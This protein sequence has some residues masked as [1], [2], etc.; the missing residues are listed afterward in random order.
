MTLAPARHM[1]HREQRCT[2][3]GFIATAAGVRGDGHN[4]FQCQ[5]CGTSVWPPREPL[6]SPPRRLWRL[7]HGASL[8]EAVL[9][10]TR[11][12][13]VECRLFLNERFCYSE[14]HASAE[15]AVEAAN[16]HRERRETDGWC[17]ET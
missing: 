17:V 16:G 8:L 7:R 5:L 10:D 15:D 6:A 3:C 4:R 1:I 2:A 12:W 14:R 9:V 13:G 11:P